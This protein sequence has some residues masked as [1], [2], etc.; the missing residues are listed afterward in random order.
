MLWYNCFCSPPHR[1][2]RDSSSSC[3]PLRR[4][5]VAEK[6]AGASKAS[7]AASPQR[8]AGEWSEAA[9]RVLRERYLLKGAQGVVTETPDATAWRVAEAVASAEKQWTNKGGSSPDAIA[10]QFYSVMVERKFLP[11]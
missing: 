10:E 3:I 8:K 2:V 1:L 7:T 6:K 11:N 9:K 5:A 4:A